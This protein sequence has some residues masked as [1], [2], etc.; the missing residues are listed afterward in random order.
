MKLDL[1]IYRAYN[2]DISNKSDKEL[3][4]HFHSS[5]KF[6]RRIFASC[7]TTAERFS[8]RWCRGSG[9]EIGAGRSPTKLFGDAQSVQADIEGAEYF[10][11]SNF[12]TYSLNEEVP[13]ELAEKFDFVISSHVLETPR[14]GA[15]LYS[16]RI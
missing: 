3:K 4:K 15:V 11:N 12:I 1:A 13:S 6:E 9:L 16:G 8:M 7:D 14:S 5:G 2:N 10:G